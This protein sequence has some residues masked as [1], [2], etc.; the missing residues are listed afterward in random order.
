MENGI[1]PLDNIMNGDVSPIESASVSRDE[2][3]GAVRNLQEQL[4]RLQADFVNFRRRVSNIADQAANDRSAE[5]LM[6]LL[7]VLDN[8]D[9]ALAAETC[10]AAYAEGVSLTYRHLLNVLKNLGL[11]PIPAV[12]EAFDPHIHEAITRVMTDEAA[13]GTVL[14]EFRKG[15]L[16]KGMLLRPAQVSVAASPGKD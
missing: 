9:R 16:L 12:R 10:D 2:L 14:Q 15:Y 6:L 11:E 1:R 4:Q 7:P 13:D 8:F 3:S 5:I